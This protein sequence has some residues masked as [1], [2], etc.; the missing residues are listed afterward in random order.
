MERVQVEA[1]AKVKER[2]TRL[3][4]YRES[5]CHRAAKSSGD[6]A[7][8]GSH[9]RH[10]GGATTAPHQRRQASAN[11]AQHSMAAPAPQAHQQQQG[12]QLQQT[13]Q[14]VGTV[15]KY[16][17]QGVYKPARLGAGLH[18]MSAQL[19]NFLGPNLGASIPDGL[20]PPMGEEP[21]AAFLR[22][23]H[24]VMQRMDLPT[25]QQQAVFA[26]VDIGVLSETCGNVARPT[27][28]VHGKN[29]RVASKRSS[30]LHMDENANPNIL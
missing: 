4:S 16:Y 30:K 28:G 25:G 15:Q 21:Q 7:A 27:G 12:E 6:A 19:E 2:Q 24:K 3:F 22:R 14:P 11:A 23:F 10:S 18:L 5:W 29:T 26:P 17:M 8:H 9:A 20:E 13:V 1:I